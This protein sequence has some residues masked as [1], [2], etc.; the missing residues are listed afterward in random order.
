MPPLKPNKRAEKELKKKQ[1]QHKNLNLLLLLL[2]LLPLTT[3]EIPLMQCSR[4]MTNLPRERLSDL[5][6][7]AALPRVPAAETVRPQRLVE[8][9]CHPLLRRG[10]TGPGREDVE[11]VL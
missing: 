9:V 11:V 3:I 4:L 8:V 2:L 6:D 10:V 7:A 5:G 1:Q